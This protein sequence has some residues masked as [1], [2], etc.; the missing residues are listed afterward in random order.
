[1]SSTGQTRVSHIPTLLAFS[2]GKIHLSLDNRGF[3]ITENIPV[4]YAGPNMSILIDLVFLYQA[5]KNTRGDNI[6][7]EIRGEAAP[8]VITDME[9]EHINVIVPRIPQP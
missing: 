8:M 4:T 1:V 7:L 5:I 9:E 3:S 2:T 6:R